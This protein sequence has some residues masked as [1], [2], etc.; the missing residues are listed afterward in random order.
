MVRYFRPIL[1]VLLPD[2]A[3]NLAEVNVVLDAARF[4]LGE[5]RLDRT[6]IAWAPNPD[7]SVIF[8]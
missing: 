6:Q 5:N 3:S 4:K 8:G 7:K 2:Q 1:T